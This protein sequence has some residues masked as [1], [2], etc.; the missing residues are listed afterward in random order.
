MNRT[1]IAS[2]ALVAALVSTSV[3]AQQQRKYDAW[4][5]PNAPQQVEYETPEHTKKMVRELREL[6]RVGRRD[7]AAAPAFLDD[8]ERTLDRHRRADRALAEETKQAA[9]P[10]PQPQPQ[11]QVNR[12]AAIEDDFSDGDFTSNPEWKLVR[13]EF[14]VARGARLFSFVQPQ[15]RP[16]NDSEA[17]AQIFGT[18]L[19]G[20]RNESRQGSAEPAAIFL[21]SPITN[22][23]EIRTQLMSDERTGGIIEMGV[24]QGRDGENGY[25]LQF[26]NGEVRMIRVGRSTVVIGTATFDFPPRV[27]GRPG[28]YE[29]LWN[30]SKRGKMQVFINGVG[31]MTATDNG[32][33]D[34]WDGFRLVNA[35]GRHGMDAIRISMRP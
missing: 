10:A 15:R 19:G 6:L 16:A 1:A 27:G 7:R 17:I 5:D 21:P 2:A 25:R 29:V 22:A 20:N 28:T 12:F 35:E 33:R 14:F 31:H 8:L 18:L 34:D 11:P 32:F 13:G 26:N 23:F 3:S 30:R 24:Y 9:A 4:S